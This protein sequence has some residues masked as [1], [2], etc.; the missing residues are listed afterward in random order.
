MK[1]KIISQISLEI[2][3][4]MENGRD[5]PLSIK[6]LKIIISQ[7]LTVEFMRKTEINNQVAKTADYEIANFAK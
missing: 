4:N 5:R 7:H 3:F 6:S 2:I 1:G